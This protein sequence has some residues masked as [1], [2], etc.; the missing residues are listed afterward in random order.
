MDGLQGSTR[1]RIS[2]DDARHLGS[3]ALVVGAAATVAFVIE[4]VLPLLDTHRFAGIAAA[5]VLSIILN[6]VRTWA[7]DTRYLSLT[8]LP[9]DIVPS[10]NWTPPP[11][12]P[13]MW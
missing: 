13:V 10:T 1:F 8:R 2:K 11:A 6:T 12:P 4:S 3:Q 7:A 5:T 9:A